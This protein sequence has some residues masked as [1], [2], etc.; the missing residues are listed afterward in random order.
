MPWFPPLSWR[1]REKL[2]FRGSA[3]AIAAALAVLPAV[4]FLILT[5]RLR[6]SYIVAAFVLPLLVTSELWGLLMLVRCCAHQAFD[7][8]TMLAF[9]ALVVVG[10]VAAYTGMF[11]AVLAG[12]LY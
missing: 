2:F 4:I 12:K 3:L 8:L 10:A 1:E 5:P 11:L 9:G 7:L 6:H